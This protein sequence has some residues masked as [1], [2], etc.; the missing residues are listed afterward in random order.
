MKVYW[1]APNRVLREGH[2]EREA[3][4]GA[5]GWFETKR[6]K[7]QR[8]SHSREQELQTEANPI[9]FIHLKEMFGELNVDTKP[10]PGAE[11]MDVISAPN[12]IG[13]TRFFFDRETHLL[14]RI[15][16]F[17]TNSAYFTETTE[18]ADYKDVDGIKLPRRILR[19]SQE[20]GL[21]KDDVR[22]SNIRQ[23]VPLDPEIFRKPDIG[24]VVVGGKH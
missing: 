15:E 17:G 10:S 18:F 13:A 16:E 23:N 4:D 1:S 7:I 2:R 9:R 14:A 21:G 19:R 5:N 11:G 3:Y 22:L 6:R 8:L 12:K 20:P 24:K